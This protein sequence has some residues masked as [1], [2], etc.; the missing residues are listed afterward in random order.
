MR[1][2]GSAVPRGRLTIARSEA[3]KDPLP[4]RCGLTVGEGAGSVCHKSWLMQDGLAAVVAFEFALEGVRFSR[5]A[6]EG[7]SRIVPPR[8]ARVNPDRARAADPPLDTGA[9]DRS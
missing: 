6:P 1:R 3:Q 5:A 4:F 8:V 7:V 2:D 9:G